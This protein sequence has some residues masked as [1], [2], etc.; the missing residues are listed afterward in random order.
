MV[1][2][3]PALTASSQCVCAFGGSISITFGGATDA[4]VA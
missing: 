1:A 4:N 3:M 2:N